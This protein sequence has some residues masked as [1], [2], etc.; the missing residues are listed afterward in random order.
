LQN[1]RG[2]VVL[3]E[4]QLRSD[5][6]PILRVL[7]D[8]EESPAQFLILGSASPDLIKGTAQSLAGRVE[9]IEVTPFSYLEARSKPLHWVRGGYPLSFLAANDEDSAAWREAFVQRFF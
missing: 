9:T 7:S 3:D 4:I 6:F 1:L 2:L 5:L 8:R